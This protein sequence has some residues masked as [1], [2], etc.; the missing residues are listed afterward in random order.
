MGATIKMGKTA[1]GMGQ[2]GQVG[3]MHVEGVRRMKKY[4]T[5]DE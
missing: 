1:I 4:V 2:M 3:Q 5:Y